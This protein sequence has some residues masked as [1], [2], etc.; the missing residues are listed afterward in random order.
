M[1]LL[2]DRGVEHWLNYGRQLEAHLSRPDNHAPDV[3]LGSVASAESD[4]HRM[5]RVLGLKSERA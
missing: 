4:L 5:A 3:I 1:L 2:P